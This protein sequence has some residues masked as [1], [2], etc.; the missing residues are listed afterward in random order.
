MIFLFQ[1]LPQGDVEEDPGLYPG[2]ILP[3]R[4]SPLDGFLFGLLSQLLISDVNAIQSDHCSNHLTLK[5]YIKLHFFK[6]FIG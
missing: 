3:P 6:S 1:N 4:F 2:R 5:F